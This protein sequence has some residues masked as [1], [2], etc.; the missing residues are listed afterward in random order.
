MYFA[1][2]VDD[3]EG[4]YEY[5]VKKCT[6][7]LDFEIRSKYPVLERILSNYGIDIEDFIQKMK[8]AVVFHDFGKLNSYFQEFMKRIIEKKKLSGIGYWIGRL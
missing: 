6:E 3:Y 1:K 5:H 4:T 2:P 8:T 7:I